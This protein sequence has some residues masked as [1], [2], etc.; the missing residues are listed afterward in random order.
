MVPLPPRTGTGGPSPTRNSFALSAIGNFPLRPMAL[1]RQT[2][3][4]SKT[5]VQQPATVFQGEAIP[6][7]GEIRFDLDWAARFFGFA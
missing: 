6:N 3:A 4:E 1:V 2:K 7:A 5:R